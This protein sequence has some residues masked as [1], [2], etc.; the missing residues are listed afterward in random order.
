VEVI[1]VFFAVKK[2]CG[3]DAAVVRLDAWVAVVGAAG[4]SEFH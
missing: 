2:G 1:V 3:C 4:G